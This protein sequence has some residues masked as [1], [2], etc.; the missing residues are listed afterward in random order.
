MESGSCARAPRAGA[1]CA[2]SMAAGARLAGEVPQAD[3]VRPHEPNGSADPRPT[4]TRLR[5]PGHEAP[6]RSVLLVLRVLV[7][8]DGVERDLDDLLRV[9]VPVRDRQLVAGVRV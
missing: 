2:S 6:R 1:G 3:A 4:V 8:L 7:L 5:K 9:V